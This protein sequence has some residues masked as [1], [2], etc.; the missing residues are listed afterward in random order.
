MTRLRAS[1][2]ETLRHFDALEGEATVGE[3]AARL[4]I[5]ERSA[6]ERIYRLVHAGCLSSRYRGPSWDA[7]YF[8]ELT[9]LRREV[10]DESE[11]RE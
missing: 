10:L 6:E 8:Y 9:N 1:Q 7:R 2:V 3:I 5:T 11:G 4:D